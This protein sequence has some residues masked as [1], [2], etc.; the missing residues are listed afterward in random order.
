MADFRI[1]PSPEPASAA[2][3][4]MADPLPD[5]VLEALEA[6]QRIE[7]IRRLREARGIGLKQARTLVDAAAVPRPTRQPRP[8]PR[9]AL[10]FAVDRHASRGP[11]PEVLVSLVAGAAAL[12]LVLISRR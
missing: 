1:G 3:F 5:D 10:G 12:L 6:G 7:A 4:F 2:G 11:A 8:G 9:T